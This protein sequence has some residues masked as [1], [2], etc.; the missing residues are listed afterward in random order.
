[1]AQFFTDSELSKV[2]HAASTLDKVTQFCLFTFVTFSMFSIS[3]T[4]IAFAIGTLSWLLKVYLTQTWKDVR[5]T[6]VGIAVLCFCLA[7]VLALISSVDLGSTI[8]H[9]KK[10][11]QFIILFWVAN[12]V[13]NEKQRNLLAILVIVFGVVATVN[14]LL[15]L[16]D[17][18]YFSAG[19]Y[20]STHTTIRPIGTMSVPA[21]FS[22]I[23]MLIG[24]VAMGRWLLSKPKEYW[25]L[26]SIGII[27]LGIMLTL[28]RQVWLGF[29][30]GSLFLLF[31]WNKKVFS[32]F[33]VLSIL[34]LLLVPPTNPKTGIHPWG[35]IFSIVHSLKNLQD[36]HLHARFSIWKGGWEIFKDH[37]ITGCGSKCVDLIHYQYPDPSGW[38]AHYR[39]M[40]STL[41]QLLVDTGIVGLGTWISIWIAYFIEIFKRWQPLTLTK[42]Q[43]NEA[44]ILIGSSAATIAFLV[45]GIFET[46]IYD[47]E[48][49]MLLYFLMGLSL[50]NVK[51]NELG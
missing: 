45:G 20:G 4:Q 17:H 16:I 41:M 46:N 49:A 12:T 6:C 48:I 29:S 35:Y 10:L 25:A 3:I 2:D 7:C 18:D 28:T 31:I 22:G 30:I 21:T 32:A 51:K 23:L 47:S 27:T 11:L 15:P 1:M 24:L 36:K 44:G 19:I 33:A 14:G 5:G 50:A 37:P 38:V 34:V 39:G 43:D 40:H 13:Q 8:K 9:L 26:I 42:F